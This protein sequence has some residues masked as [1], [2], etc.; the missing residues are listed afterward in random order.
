[1]ISCDTND[2][3]N[4]AA[5]LECLD[6]KTLIGSKTFLLCQLAN[7]SPW[8]EPPQIVNVW[9]GTGETDDHIATAVS[10]SAG[11]LLVIAMATYLADVSSVSDNI[12]G[13]TGWTKINSSASGN[14]SVV[15]MWYKE[16]IPTGITTVTATAIGGQYVTAIIHEVSGAS[17]TAAYT[18]ESAVLASIA[19]ANPQVGPV[20]NGTAASIF[21]AALT[22]NGV[23]NPMTI[24]S[25]G[26]V[27]VWNL[28]SPTLSQETDEVNFSII[29]V[30]NIVVTSAIAETHG[31]T[32]PNADCEAVSACFHV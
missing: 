14:G 20:T 31:W 29:S 13:I 4:Q 23:G 26:T 7:S 6:E 12:D 32:T 25:T 5:C 27:G 11:N 16:N 19:T 17:Q 30:P 18:G 28:Y 15:A 3:A 8:I 2:L 10:P 9:K 1:M 24:N 22:D 21:F